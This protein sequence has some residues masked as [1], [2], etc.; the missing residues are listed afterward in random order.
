MA[1]SNWDISGGGGQAVIDVDGS[2]RCQLSGIKYMLWNGRD[3][4]VNAE[5]VATI[6]PW[7][8]ENSARQKGGMLLRC[9]ISI[10]NYYRLL[11]YA[12]TN[13]RVY[14]ITR[15]INGVATTLSSI[16]SYQ[17]YNIHVKTR[18]RIDGW[19]ISVEEYTGGSWNL[20]TTIEDTDHT[21]TSGYVGLCGINYNTG[22]SFLFD[23]IEI[24]ERT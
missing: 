5:I 2:K 15:V 10:M 20:I 12:Y 1:K 23:D 24:S 17:A 4:V 13:Y 7:T 22:Y 19:Q 21:I 18:F 14:Y 9:D 8:N 3:N 6:K 11:A 16:I